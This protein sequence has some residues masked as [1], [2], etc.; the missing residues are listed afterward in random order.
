MVSCKKIPFFLFILSA[1]SSFSQNYY[2]APKALTPPVIDGLGNDSIWSKSNWHMVDQLWL[3]V[4]PNADDF[5]EYFK[6]S[7]DS[8]K[9]Y[10][11]AQVTDDSLSDHYSNPLSSYW[12]DDTWE[13]FIDEDKSGGA[14][15]TNYNAFGYH[16]SKSLDA[17]DVG[18]DGSPHL[19]NSNLT[20]QRTANGKIYT[21]EAAFDV[22]T[23]AFVYGALNNPK[24]T[25][26][27]GK[28]MGFAMAY[29]DNDGG[30]TRQS[31][32]GSEVVAGVDKNVAYKN[33]SVFG[34]LELLDSISSTA[35]VPVN[36]PQNFSVFPN[37]AGDN[38]TVQ[39]K[40][41][42]G[43]LELFDIY[44]SLVLTQEISSDSCQLNLENLSSGVY[45]LR[46]SS[47]GK[48]HSQKLVVE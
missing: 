37:P 20:V 16:I 26:F 7:W 13:V 43:K 28:I 10:V 39:L 48:S 42:T 2:Q 27:A 32:I 24:A 15:E 6:V 9:L 23:D 30:T 45:L 22:Y 19:Y 34:T 3:G 25:L 8:N 36:E 4:Q 12:E 11:L 44:S 33:A 18:T 46:Y 35:I 21:W 38:I 1:F 17:V 14:H 29:C 31:F 5:T 40:A 41:S 47:A